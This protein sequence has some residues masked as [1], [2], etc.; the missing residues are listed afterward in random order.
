MSEF[1]EFDATIGAMHKSLDNIKRD[2]ERL[3]YIYSKSKNSSNGNKSILFDPD[4]YELVDKISVKRLMDVDPRL[5]VIAAETI[6]EF[7]KMPQSAAFLRVSS[8]KRTKQEQQALFDAGKSR[9]LNS[10][11][12]IGKAVDFAI[13]RKGKADFSSIGEYKDIYKM[14]KAIADRLFGNEL[15]LEWGGEVFGPDFIDAVHIQIRDI[16]T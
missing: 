12:L 5:A 6:L 11:H 4:Y 3:R 13:I 16:A 10:K 2:L 7:D 1:K 9:T 15:V 14:A 8:G